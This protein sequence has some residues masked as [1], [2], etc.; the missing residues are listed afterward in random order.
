MVGTSFCCRCMC[1]SAG[2][3]RDRCGSGDLRLITPQGIQGRHEP[4]SGMASRWAPRS[5]AS[6]ERRED[7]GNHARGPVILMLDKSY[8]DIILRF[9]TIEC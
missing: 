3:V 8:Q 9:A 7:R 2:D 5:G 1:H 4:L 6:G